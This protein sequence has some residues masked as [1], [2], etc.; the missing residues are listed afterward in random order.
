MKKKIFSIFLVFVMLAS[1]ASCSKIKDKVS[2]PDEVYDIQHFEELKK[3]YNVMSVPCLVINNDKV[4]FGKKNIN[5]V[6]DLIK[7]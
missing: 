4:S 3:K 7:H 2:L 1:F 5:Q 6:L